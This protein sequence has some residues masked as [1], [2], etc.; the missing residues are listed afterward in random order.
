MGETCWGGTKRIHARAADGVPSSPR[1]PKVKPPVI[2][3]RHL[4]VAFRKPVLR[5]LSLH[6]PEGSTYALVGP[7]GA[8][9]TVLMKCLAGLLNPEAG[10][11]TVAGTNITHA[12][13]EARAALR[14]RI[15][16]LFQNYA[17]FDFCTVGENIAFPLEQAGEAD[18]VAIR[19]RVEAELAR[20]ALSGFADRAIRGLSGG[21]KKRVGLARATV[22]RPEIVLYDE[23]TAGLDPVTSRKIWDLLAQDTRQTRRT[24]VVVSSDVEG[25]LSIADRVGVLVDGTLRFEGTVEDAM[26]CRIPEVHQFLHG[27]TE[28]PL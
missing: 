9:K 22:A 21:Q 3:V 4:A 2:T 18:A 16:M 12:P 24:A 28:G 26:A 6:V 14:A 19:D 23:P 10:D 25:V 15:G 27:E 7:G 11:V 17:L 8:G 5:D 1:W 20:V 13:H